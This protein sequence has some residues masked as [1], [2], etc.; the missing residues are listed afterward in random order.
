V[1]VQTEHDAHVRAESPHEVRAAV[2]RAVGRAPAGHQAPQ[3]ELAGP[4]PVAT[5][6][7][8]SAPACTTTVPHA[9]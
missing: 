1:S 9:S 5:R 8:T 2:L 3:L 6:S 7:V 4:D